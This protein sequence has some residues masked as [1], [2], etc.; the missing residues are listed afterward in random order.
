MKTEAAS[1]ELTPRAI[2]RELDK[3]IVGQ[4]EA[5]KVVAIALR[6]RMRRRLLDEAL[7]EEVNPKN[8]IMIGPTGVGKTEIA[9]RLARLVHSPFVK[10]EATKY[11]EVGYVGRDVESM[12]RDLVETSVNMVREQMTEAVR[13]EAKRRARERLLDLLGPDGA[14]SRGRR[15]FLG[16][17]GSQEAA[18]EGESAEEGAAGHTREQL[19]K[20]LDSGALDSREVEVE[21]TARPAIEGMFGVV[22]VDDQ[23]MGGL[24]DMMEKLMPQKKHHS[25]VSVGEARRL[26][27]EQEAEA[28]L[29]QE[30]MTREALER[31]EQSGIIFID[32]ID[33]IAGRHAGAGPD[34]SREGV[35][36][37]ILPIV[38][39]SAVFTKY[40]TIRTD[41]IL[42]IAAGAFHATKPSDL[43]PELQ[44]R[45]PLR[46]ELKS[47]DTDDFKRILVEPENSL[48]KQYIALLKTDG[49]ALDFTDDAIEELARSATVINSQAENIGARRLHTILE[50]VLESVAFDAPDDVQGR[51]V[52]DRAYVHERLKDLLENQDLSRFIL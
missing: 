45:F 35:Q 8:I 30:K 42:F 27:T 15:R 47:L 48:I 46:V 18:V 43:I 49:V 29:D 34:V 24:R 7:R 6:N 4:H 28:M 13:P 50:R 33:K 17:L 12:V 38:E 36:R 52:I 1:E 10:V 9:R 44:G 39:G 16:G 21:V 31:A 51:V 5:K 19:A 40:G 41:H 25:R 2:V 37:D 23:M 11:T 20:L 32:E 3:Y 26:L 14:P 22:G